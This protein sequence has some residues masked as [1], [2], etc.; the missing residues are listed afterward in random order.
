MTSSTLD[1]VEAEEIV[2]SE[3]VKRGWTDV[4]HIHKCIALTDYL[5]LSSTVLQ[6]LVH[7]PAFV[8]WLIY[9]PGHSVNQCCLEQ[10][11]VCA[12]I[13][14]L[15]LFQMERVYQSE[16]FCRI[17]TGVSEEKDA[18]K[19]L[20]KFITRLHVDFIKSYAPKRRLSLQSERTSPVFQIFGGLWKI[21]ALCCGKT[22]KI[23]K[24][25][26]NIAVPLTSSHIQSCLDAAIQELST[27]CLCS[28]CGSELCAA[29][30]SVDSPPTVLCLNLERFQ[31]D[32]SIDD[33]EV[34]VEP[35]I[36]LDKKY[37]Y[38]LLSLILANGMSREAA[39]YF[40]ITICPGGVI[41]EFRGASEST[42][43]KPVTSVEKNWTVSPILDSSSTPTT[44]VSLP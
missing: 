28:E 4:P 41:H 17:I 37:S 3:E 18:Q 43:I 24:S 16:K 15:S 6:A 29:S 26:L 14:F 33:R 9:S 32:G 23:L 13:D 7:V 2:Y 22:Y 19:Y 35:R 5:S 44:Q 25:S 27:K 21:S 34:L 11:L 12:L 1:R 40:P 8:H 42:P 36:T 38:N 30:V 31:E 20:E 39:T 10:C